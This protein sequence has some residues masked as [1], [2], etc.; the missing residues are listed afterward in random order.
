MAGEKFSQE[1]IDRALRKFVD[2]WEGKSSE[3]I[4]SVYNVPSYRQ[5]QDAD[6]MV[7]M[8]VEC[9]RK[10]AAGGEEEI[11]P[12]FWPDFGTVSTA[13]IWGGK[14]IPPPPG[15]CI[16]IEPVAHSP[17]DL[18]K[19]RPSPFERTDFQRG[20]D[21]YRRVQKAYGG[22]L[23]TRTPDFQGPMNTLALIMDQTELM[24]AFY[25]AP[26]AIHAAL[27]HITDILIEFVGRYVRTIGPG[28]VVGNSWPYLSLPATM[29]ISITQD[30]MPLMGPDVYAEF[31]I[32]RLKRIADKF[33]GVWIHCC[34]VYRQHLQVLRN[35][36]FKIRGLELAYPQMG[37]QE[38]YDVFGDDIA[39]LV[40]VSPDGE[41]EF[42]SIAAYARH[43]SEQPCAKGRFWF[44][45][46]HE[47]V[48]ADELRNVVKNGFGRDK[49]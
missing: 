32:P 13:A 25:E 29:G 23:F 26:Q 36:G 24:C 21:I 17:A 10:D 46:C 48:D 12:C 42:P 14:I 33:G 40:G 1:R 7:E 34:G 2:F 44:A 41:R 4:V 22:T 18:A 37:P 9:I 28:L 43:L 31:E 6:R 27:D 30:Y 11:L 19:L 20:I 45:S 35:S 47:W 49:A 38:V 15:G 16:H 8:A 5:E 3:P 39:Y